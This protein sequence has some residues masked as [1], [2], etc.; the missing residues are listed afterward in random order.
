[1][2]LVHRKLAFLSNTDKHKRRFRANRNSPWPGVASL[3]PGSPFDPF[4]VACFGVGSSTGA[5]AVQR[6]GA[7]S[8][9]AMGPGV[10]A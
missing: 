7:T 2:D 1:M 6:H 4:S 9:S 3:P 10:E 8:C 5:A